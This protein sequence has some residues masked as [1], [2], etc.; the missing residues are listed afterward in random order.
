MI[1]TVLA[2]GQYQRVALA[3]MNMAFGQQRRTRGVSPGALPQATVIG[4]LRPNRFLGC[5]HWP[6]LGAIAIA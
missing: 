2:E 3:R 4:G 5:G 6:A 1:A